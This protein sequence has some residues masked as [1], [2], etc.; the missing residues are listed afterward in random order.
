L[1]HCIW[2][3]DSQIKIYLF[4]NRIAPHL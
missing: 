2:K 1:F 3:P 4:A